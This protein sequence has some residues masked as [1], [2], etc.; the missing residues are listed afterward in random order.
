MGFGNGKEMWFV[1]NRLKYDKCG[2]NHLSVRA[3]SYSVDQCLV[4][5]DVLYST[6]VI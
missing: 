5:D 6:P 4:F 3:M 1:V 2:C